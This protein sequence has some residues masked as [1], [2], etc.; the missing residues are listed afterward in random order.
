MNSKG[1]VALK[2]TS[3]CMKCLKKKATHTYT[4]YGRGYGSSFD[5]SDTKFQCCDDC[6]KPEYEDNMFPD[7]KTTDD[8]FIFFTYWLIWPFMLCFRYIPKAL[9][10]LGKFIV[11]YFTWSIAKI[12][13]L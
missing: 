8:K 9:Y 5:M 13:K 11:N 12:F 2:D 7:L 10:L 3:V 1:I 6:D 4:I